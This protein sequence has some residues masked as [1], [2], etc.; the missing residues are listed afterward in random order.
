MFY[1]IGA[2]VVV[3]LHLGFILFVVLGG[4]L[5]LRWTVVAW[6]HVPAAIWGILIEFYRWICPLTPLENFL[7]RASGIAGYKGSFVDHYLI[8]IIYP[9]V[10]NRTVQIILGSFVLILNV[11]VYFFVVRKIVRGRRMDHV[12][13][14]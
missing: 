12:T 2:D 5:A 8:P 10:L 14:K 7:R 13:E 9:V 3:V 11:V 6:F 4:F 1:R